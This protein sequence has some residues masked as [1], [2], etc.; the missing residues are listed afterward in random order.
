M[1]LWC[2]TWKRCRILLT[3]RDDVGKKFE[4]KNSCNFGRIW[5]A[6]SAVRGNQQ[7]LQCGWCIKINLRGRKNNLYVRGVRKHLGK[8]KKS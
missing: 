8:F 6:D 5:P 7:D 1:Q 2:K 3:C 4:Q